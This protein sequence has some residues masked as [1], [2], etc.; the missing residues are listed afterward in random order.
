VLISLLQE[1]IDGA[2]N[3]FEGRLN[4]WLK[5]H[6]VQGHLCHGMLSLQAL[7]KRA[8]EQS[9]SQPETE[10]KR[11]ATSS[12]ATGLGISHRNHPGKVDFSSIQAFPT[13]GLIPPSPNPQA[14]G[15]KTPSANGGSTAAGEC[16]RKEAVTL[17]T[18][19]PAV[20]GRDLLNLDLTGLA[21]GAPDAMA[22]PHFWAEVC[23]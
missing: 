22:L 4:T 1:D 8:I 18:P 2:V 16:V 5:A 3:I 21:G 12:S 6:P 17:L 20:S 14:A 11:P 9:R 13:T 19:G 10:Q 23:E 15:V 7:T